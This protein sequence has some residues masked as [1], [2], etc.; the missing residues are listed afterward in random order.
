MAAIDPTAELWNYASSFLPPDLDR[1]ALE[2]GALRRCRRVGNASELLRLLLCCVQ[3]GGSFR[4]ASA[5]CDAAGL[6]KLS[7]EG[8]FYRMKISEEFLSSVLGS[9]VLNWR[10]ISCQRRLVI[11]DATVL[12]GLA[13]RGTD[14]RLH[15][16]YDPLRAVPCG[17]CLTDASQGESLALHDLRKGD[18]ALAD[19]GYGH[20]RGFRSA[21]EKG[22]DVLVR[23]VPAQM[24]LTDLEGTPV[25]L[26]GLAGQVPSAGCASFDLVWHGPD[27]DCMKVRIIGA[28][29]KGQEPCWL[30]TNLGKEELPDAE[31]ASLYG[32]RW[33]I[34]LLFKRL[35]SL[36]KLGDLRSREG[37]TVKAFIYAKLITAVLALRLADPGEAFSP[38]GYA[39]HA[40][41]AQ[42]MAGVPVRHHRLGRSASR[43]G[44]LGAR[45]PL[46]TQAAF[47]QAQA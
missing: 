13:S 41:K 43:S 33:Q 8:L 5:W 34:E 39:I 11:V 1:L 44:S 24:K 42:P 32:C 35:K 38:Y 25:H 26:S 21:L 47:Q 7:A 23:L 17:F 10:D 36:L 16:L 12:S 3:P 2:S 14:W 46:A 19:R 30:A 20:F 28:D 18:L 40:P 27:G 29:R 22:A 9:L 15:A 31:A 4:T 6:G 45:R 37:P